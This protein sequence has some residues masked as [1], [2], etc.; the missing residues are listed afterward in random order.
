MEQHTQVLMT[1]APHNA[2]DS[3][4]GCP[5]A[6][7]AIDGLILANTPVI[8]FA[9][10]ATGTIT[11]ME[12]KGLERLTV[13]PSACVGR[14]AF[15]P[16]CQLPGFPDVVTRALTGESVSFT[17]ELD[18]LAYDV[19]GSPVRND[20]SA[21]TGMIGVAIDTTERKH[22]ERQ[23]YQQE[24]LALLGQLAGGIAHDF[25]N[26]L[27]IIIVYARMI[28]NNQ[29]RPPHLR[30]AAET[31]IGESRR[32]SDLIN[33]ILDFSRRSSIKLR[34]V[35][36]ARFLEDVTA[37]LSKTLPD[38]IRLTTDID[39]TQAVVNAD[40]TRIQQLI[41]NLAVNARDAMLDG[42]DLRIG[43][44]P[45]VVE[46]GETPPL[47]TLEP[48][49]WICLSVADT[50]VGMPE[51]VLAHLFEP[52]FT[53]K[54]AHGTGLGL[55]QVYGIVQQHRGH[56]DV[57]SSV[58]K[59]TTFRIYLHAAQAEQ[60]TQPHSGTR[61][62][63]CTSAKKGRILFVEDEVALREASCRTLAAWGYE[64]LT[65]ANEQEAVALFQTRQHDPCGEDGPDLVIADVGVTDMGGRALVRKL[66]ELDPAVK[67][68]GITGR[69]PDSSGEFETA[70]FLDVVHR[71]LDAATLAASIRKA[72]GT[73]EW[74]AERL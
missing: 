63:A 61:S 39:S 26:F 64:V 33:Q 58:G 40:P 18:D 22:L 60:A 45:V 57:E 20:D 65:A 72:L 41:M 74:A 17:A 71:P 67:V 3:T 11:L 13:T 16:S 66:R 36:L 34:P 52:F 23:V 59:G 38:D 46:P 43:L 5:G 21:V 49:H 4:S 1:Q 2:P 37:M 30:A 62:I 31:I 42:G 7:S 54:G 35:H 25:N 68:L 69:N 51:E 14:S 27:T 73:D 8:L 24:R 10:D 50:G 32:A 6:P 28:L 70:G 29:D 44:R 15:D 53:T 9:V 48:G 47:P 12:G 56:I 19:W 55:P